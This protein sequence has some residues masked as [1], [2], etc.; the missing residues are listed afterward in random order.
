MSRLDAPRAGAGL[1]AFLMQTY[2][3][4]VGVG[5]IGPLHLPARGRFATG[6]LPI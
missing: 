5:A 4:Q 1:E 2:H 6:T 3:V